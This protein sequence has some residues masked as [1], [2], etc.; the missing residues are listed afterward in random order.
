M[1]YAE[2]LL[3]GSDIARA[4]GTS[5]EVSDEGAA[6]LR[7]TVAETAELGRQMGA[8]GD[9]VAVD[10]DATDFETALGSAGRDPA[11]AR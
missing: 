10:P 5:L 1:A 2:I 11:W 4:T 8:Y 7:R 9:P 6:A 3:H